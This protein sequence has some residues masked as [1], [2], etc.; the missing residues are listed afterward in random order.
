MFASCA[1]DG[2]A[3]LFSSHAIAELERICDYLVVLRKGRVQVAGDIDDLRGRHRVISGPADWPQRAR[4]PVISVTHIADRT[5]ALVRLDS[6]A[7]IGPGLDQAEP[8][9]DELA[10]GYLAAAQPLCNDAPA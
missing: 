6:A 9:F 3:V 7:G 8:T 2:V 10:L 1:E 4:L 5:V